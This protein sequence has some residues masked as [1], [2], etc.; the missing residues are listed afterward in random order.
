MPTQAAGELMT[1]STLAPPENYSLPRWAQQVLQYVEARQNP[2]GGYFFAQG[3]DSGAQDTYY[4]LDIFNLLRT[5]PPNLEA[6][7]DWLRKFPADNVYAYFYVGK[8]LALHK[9]QVDQKIVQRLLELRK[10]HGG[11]SEIDVNIEAYSEFEATYRATEV[12]RELHVPVDTEPTAQWL[13]NSMNTDGG[14]GRGCSNLISTFHA[15]SSLCNLGY[16]IRELKKT[17]QFV[18]SCEKKRGGFTVVS[19]VSLPF[20]QEV[21]AGA[22]ILRI[23]DEPFTYP[24]ATTE[25]VLGLQNSNGG[26]RRSIELGLSTFE[27]TYYALS[28]YEST[29]QPK[30]NEIHV[31]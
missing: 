9:R 11:Y 6:T 24:K 15:L 5:G 20:L 1:K 26:F 13:L 17:L 30:A 25:L 3:A 4:A 29:R 16:Q 12:L 22:T 18:R 28:T 2:D 19:E 14:F 8:G 10:P 7:I 31:A 21:Y 23:M 27:D